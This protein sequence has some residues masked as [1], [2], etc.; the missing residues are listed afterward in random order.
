MAIQKVWLH[1]QRCN[2]DDCETYAALKGKVLMLIDRAD[3]DG[4]NHIVLHDDVN[5]IIQDQYG[6]RYIITPIPDME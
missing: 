6:Q 4:A 3:V 1:G 2:C 5:T